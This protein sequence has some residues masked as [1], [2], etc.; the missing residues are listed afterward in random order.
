MKVINGIPFYRFRHQ[1]CGIWYDSDISDQLT[2]NQIA[3]LRDK[4]VTAIKKKIDLNVKAFAIPFFNKANLIPLEIVKA[5]RKEYYLGIT[6][7]FPY[8]SSIDDEPIEDRQL[9]NDAYKSLDLCFS[10]EQNPSNGGNEI[11]LKGC[12]KPVD[13]LLLYMEKYQVNRHLISFIKQV[14]IITA[15]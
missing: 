14:M 12:L 2:T 10:V 5:M 15:T 3:V 9:W 13:I 7:I 6:G 11:Y 1:L 8:N 4:I